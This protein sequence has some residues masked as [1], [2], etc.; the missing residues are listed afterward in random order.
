MRQKNTMKLWQMI[1]LGSLL[2]AVIISMFLPVISIRGIKFM[3]TFQ[4]AAVKI[5]DEKISG[6]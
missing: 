4:D 2:L 3:K 5:V 6:M 1:V